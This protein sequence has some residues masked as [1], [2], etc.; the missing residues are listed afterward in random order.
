[1]DIVQI[2]TIV[3]NVGLVIAVCVAV[4]QMERDH[5]RR[6]KQSTLET[7]LGM[8]TEVD[9]LRYKIEKLGVDPPH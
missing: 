4:V 1:M 8:S 7:W 3:A 9:Q 2:S 5:T 6:K